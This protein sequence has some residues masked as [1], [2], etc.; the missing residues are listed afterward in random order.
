MCGCVY[1]CVCVC[2]YVCVSVCVCVY[3]YTYVSQRISLLCLVFL[4]ITPYS[5]KQFYVLYHEL[6]CMKLMYQHLWRIGTVSG[7][8]CSWAVCV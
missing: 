3:I 2:V 5:I 1:V 8:L 6:N 4:C 7:T